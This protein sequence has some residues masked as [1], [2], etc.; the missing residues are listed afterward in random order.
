MTDKDK[1][2]L[3]PGPWTL[4]MNDQET[5]A[6]IEAADG[7]HVSNFDLGG[8][9]EIGGLDEWQKEMGVA[10]LLTAAGTTAHEVRQMGYDP[11]KAVEALPELLRLLEFARDAL[12]DQAR[13][14]ADAANGLAEADRVEDHLAAIARTAGEKVESHE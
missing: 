9:F 4:M 7:H 10:H 11:V 5:E 3:P 6:D 12:D 13:G 2:M 14:N 1:A 8:S